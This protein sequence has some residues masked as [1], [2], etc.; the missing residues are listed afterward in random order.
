MLLRTKL[1]LILLS[2]MAIPLVITQSMGFINARNALKQ[3][4]I[5]QVESIADQKVQRI[6]DFWLTIVKLPPN[7]EK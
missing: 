1:S 3:A 5:A 4:R 2:F 6:E 7:G